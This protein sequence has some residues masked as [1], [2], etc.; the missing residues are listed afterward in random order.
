VP[1]LSLLKAEKINGLFFLVH[2]FFMRIYI[3]VLTTA[4]YLIDI[5]DSDFALCNDKSTI[6]LSFHF[7]L[8]PQ[9][10]RQF[11]PIANSV[12]KKQSHL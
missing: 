9:A 12:I 2:I 3:P 7:S 11:F 8:Q 6:L 10:L 5:I 4:L 1:I